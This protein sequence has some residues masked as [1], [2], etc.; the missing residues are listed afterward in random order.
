MAKSQDDQALW[1][2][3]FLGDA[4]LDA[5]LDLPTSKSMMARALILA[6]ISKRPSLI[7]RP[8]RSRDSLLMRDGLRAL[9]VEIDEIEVEGESA[10]RIRPQPLKGPAK[11]DVGNAGTVMRFL[12]PIAA[13]AEGEIRFDGD[14]RSH[15]RPLRPVIEALQSLGVAI[16]HD[17]RFAL[18]LTIKGAGQLSGGEV[19][20]DAS[21]SSQFIS[22]LLLASPAM[23]GDLTIR[24]TGRSLPSLPHIEMTIAML[25]DRG[26]DVEVDSDSRT[27]RVKQGSGMIEID[28][29]TIEPD[30]SNAA[31]FIAAAL[32]MG[33]RVRIKD[34]PVSTRQ[35]GD[36]LRSIFTLMGGAFTRVGS[37][38]EFTALG[39]DALEGIDIDLGDVGELTPTIAGVAA[40]ASSKSHL[41]NIGH[42]RL[43][44]TDRLS[45]LATE[46]RKIGAQVI[47]NED[48]LEITPLSNRDHVSRDDE[49]IIESYDDHRIATLGAL[50]GLVVKNVKVRNIATTAKTIPDFPALWQKLI[51]PVS[52]RPSGN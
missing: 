33:G 48:S 21:A 29:I 18:P 36:S 17:D 45:A 50:I 5:T 6:S 26:I 3:P 13:L 37:D 7:K 19:E 52:S 49:V 42:L 46:L 15:E 11:I 32:L 1:S 20:I 23:S 9:G 34:W 47:E 38:I 27:W 44:E 24:H 31:P 35:A 30:L 28:Q 41:R 10:W 39:R 40:F 43:H 8:L 12:P 25:K 14:E 2:S 22:A 16:A 51:Q 4:Q